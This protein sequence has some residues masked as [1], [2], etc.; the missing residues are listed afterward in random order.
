[1]TDTEEPFNEDSSASAEGAAVPASPEDDAWT[2][3]RAFERLEEIVEQLEHGAA[4]LEESLRLFEEGMRLLRL[5]YQ[6]LEAAEQRI[7]I[8][9]GLDDEGRPLTVPFDA[10]ATAELQKAGRRSGTAPQAP[11]DATATP[12]AERPASSRRSGSG[13]AR[14]RRRSANP[15][16]GED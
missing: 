6:R 10:S 9:A 13:R 2:F 12:S 3:E 14:K 8:L 16:S 15:E 5:C 1:M 4:G 11:D 7:E